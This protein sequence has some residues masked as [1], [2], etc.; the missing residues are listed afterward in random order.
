MVLKLYQN[1]NYRWVLRVWI[2]RYQ[3][4]GNTETVYC[5]PALELPL[6]FLKLLLQCA[7][8]LRTAFPTAALPPPCTR[9]TCSCC[10]FHRKVPSKEYESS[11]MCPSQAEVSK[12]HF[13]LLPLSLLLCQVILSSASLSYAQH[14]QAVGG[15]QTTEEINL[16]H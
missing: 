10:Q 1:K 12:K 7:G 11:V 4:T 8:P 14:S 2:T 15:D 16:S 5:L 13:C 9:Q 3:L 6:I